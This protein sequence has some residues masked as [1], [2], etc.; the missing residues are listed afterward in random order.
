MYKIYI[1]LR[2]RGDDCG[3][4]VQWANDYTQAYKLINSVMP[5]PLPGYYYFINKLVY[6][7]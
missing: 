2:K 7:K 6:T 1:E 3:P 5:K 4:I